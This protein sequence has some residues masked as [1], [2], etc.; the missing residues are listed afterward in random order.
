MKQVACT[1]KLHNKVNY[2]ER[3]CLKRKIQ[4]SSNS[5]TFICCSTNK[6]ETA[7]EVIDI[8]I[9]LN[10]VDRVLKKQRKNDAISDFFLPFSCK[11]ISFC[12]CFC[13]RCVTSLMQKRNLRVEKK[14]GGGG[15]GRRERVGTYYNAYASFVTHLKY[16]CYIIKAATT[17]S[18]KWRIYWDVILCVNIFA[19]RCNMNAVKSVA[20]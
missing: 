18:M 7:I 13:Q 15:G 12:L 17:R 10:R 16:R 6:R 3:F 14:G 4:V 11:T 20:F 2:W 9:M 19:K 8:Y 5:N 1:F